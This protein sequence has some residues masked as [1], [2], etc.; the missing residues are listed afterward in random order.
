MKAVCRTALIIILVLV[1]AI[2]GSAQVGSQPPEHL[3]TQRGVTRVG[4]VN[5]S[6]QMFGT[7]AADRLLKTEQVL[8]PFQTL[9]LDLF[10]D[11]S[12]TVNLDRAEPQ[13]NA[14][15]WSGKV[16]GIPNSSA[17]FVVAGNILTGSVNRG[18]GK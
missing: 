13:G 4:N 18:D 9:H 10:P 8:Q 1:A 12:L 11:V 7:L 14:V 2:S 3:R 5:V 17:T 6:L 15:A 16:E